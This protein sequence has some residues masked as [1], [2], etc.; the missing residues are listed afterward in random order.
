MRI[1]VASIDMVSEVNMVSGLGTG[2]DC[3]AYADTKWTGP[4]ALCVSLAV[5]SPRTRESHSARAPRSGAHTLLPLV[6]I[7]D[8]H[9]GYCGVP[10]ET[11]SALFG[12]RRAAG[13][14]GSGGAESERY[15][16]RVSLVSGAEGTICRQPGGLHEGPRTVVLSLLLAG[17]GPAAPEPDR[18]GPATKHPSTRAHRSGFRVSRPSFQAL[19]HRVS[20]ATG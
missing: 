11:C 18:L 8:T 4:R 13:G 10:E 2:S 12:E 9:T 7:F 19:A 1:D 3:G 15:F 6:C 16:D 14:S 17:P 5:I 20:G